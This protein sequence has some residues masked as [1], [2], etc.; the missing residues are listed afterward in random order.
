MFP[1]QALAQAL[2]PAPLT[3]LAQIEASAGHADAEILRLNPPLVTLAAITAEFQDYALAA[4]YFE[5]ALAIRCVPA[6]E[7]LLAMVRKR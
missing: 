4:T 6:V 5:R 3:G 1:A 7:A 2:T